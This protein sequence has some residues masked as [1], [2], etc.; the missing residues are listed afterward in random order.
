MLGIGIIGAGDIARR[1]AQG[2]L[3][4]RDRARIVAIADIDPETTEDRAVQWG[5]KTYYTDYQEL[6]DRDDIDAVSI[7]TPNR[8]HAEMTIAAAESGKHVL[9]E[10]PIAICL[11]DADRMIAA[12]EKRRVKLQIGHHFR[13]HPYFLKVKELI[14]ARRLGRILSIKARKFKNGVLGELEASWTDRRGWDSRLFVY[15]TKGVIECIDNIDEGEIRWYTRPK[16]RVARGWMD[17]NVTRLKTFGENAYVAEI[18]DFLTAIEE[19]RE[20]SCTGWDGRSSLEAV[21]AAYRSAG[22]GKS[23]KLSLS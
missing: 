9:C 17:V 13:F 23:I 5:V 2:Y 16:D 15:G 4:N 19:D 10:K 8:L 12:C 6:L 22:E 20:P 1:H 14:D 11:D 21:L 3:K 18:T 7:C